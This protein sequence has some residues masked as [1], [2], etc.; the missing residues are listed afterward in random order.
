MLDSTQAQAPRSH[1]A[2]WRAATIACLL[3]IAIATAT[4]VSMFEQFKAQIHHLQTQLQ[5]TAQI[6]YVAVLLDDSQA[7]AMLITLDPKE[8]ALQIQR[9]NN[10]TEG[11]ADSMQLWALAANGQPRSLG[12]L[13]STGKTLR[14]PVNDKTLVD[15]SQLAI[16]VENKDETT[17]HSQPSLPYLFKGAV[18]QKAL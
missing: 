3:V 18:V 10:V 7:P 17:Q 6:R 14:L 9:L 11:R 15:V 5:S 4:G 16:S 8:A 12:I 2:W 1:G 13:A